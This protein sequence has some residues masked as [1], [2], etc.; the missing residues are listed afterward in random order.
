M[1]W[2]R[3]GS[4]R[5][6]AAPAL[7]TTCGSGTSPRSGWPPATIR[8]R[9]PR[10]ATGTTSAGSSRTPRSVTL[11]SKTNCSNTWLASP[12]RASPRPLTHPGC[13]EPKREADPW[14]PCPTRIAAQSAWQELALA[15]P[16]MC[17]VG[18]S[19]VRD[20]GRFR[21]ESTAPD[22]APRAVCVPTLQDVPVTDV[23]VVRPRELYH[24]GMTVRLVAVW[25]ETCIVEPVTTLGRGPLALPRYEFLIGDGTL[26]EFG[27]TLIGEEPLHCDVEQPILGAALDC[28]IQVRLIGVGHDE[29]IEAA[30]CRR[31]RLRPFDPSR[32]AL[33]EHEQTDDRLL[34][35][36]ARLDAPEFDTEDARAFCRLF[37]ACVRASQVIMF[38]KIFRAGSR[39]PEAQFHDE[40]ERLLRA[41]P[42]LEGRLTR[43]DAVAGGFDDLLHDDVIAEL[44]VARAAPVT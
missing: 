18:S 38:E 22:E 12:A 10:A 21:E 6:W 5:G 27:L 39:V 17:L 23:L 31:L 7:P 4:P 32:D 30:G 41:D 33:T 44:K 34:G 14:S 35:V 42:Q 15:L 16:P 25:V 28:P 26:D 1:Q 3:A 37:A 9:A 36:F 11:D 19:L 40:L 2:I 24:L 20:W 8:T 13:A 29:V 43:R